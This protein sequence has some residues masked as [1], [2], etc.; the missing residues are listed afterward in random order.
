LKTRLFTVGI[1]ARGGKILV[2]KRKKDDDTY[3]GLWDCVGGHFEEGETSEQ[4][5]LR[6]ALEESRLK[7]RIERVGKLIEYRDEYGRSVAVP[8]LLRSTSGKVV[9]SEHSEFLWLSPRE[10]REL[11]SVPSL[12]KAIDDFRL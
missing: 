4:C 9:P 2:L 8:F 10:A 3:P 5:M 6:E 11:E 1:V 7:P 12:R